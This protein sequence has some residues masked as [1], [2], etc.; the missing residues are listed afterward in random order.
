[1]GQHGKMLP[2]IGP[3]QKQQEV[4]TFLQHVIFQNS[5]RKQQNTTNL[6]MIVPHFKQSPLR[7]SLACMLSPPLMC[8]INGDRCNYFLP[9]PV[10]NSDTYT[11]LSNHA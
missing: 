6:P 9:I 2:K 7:L 10:S 8:I 11:S 5:K 1:M 3:T 4:D